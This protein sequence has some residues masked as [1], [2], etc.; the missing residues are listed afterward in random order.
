MQVVEKTIE[1]TLLQTIEKI[2]D[3][4]EI[5]TVQSTQSSESLETAPVLKM[6]PAEKVEGVEFG[7]PLSAESAPPMFA[8][9]PTVEP[10]PVVVEYIQPT[11]VV[12]Y[13]AAA[14]AVTYAALAPMVEYVRQA[15]NSDI[16]ETNEKRTLR[17]SPAD[18]EGLLRS[19]PKRWKKGSPPCWMS[20]L[21]ISTSQTRSMRVMNTYAVSGPRRKVSPAFSGTA[22]RNASPSRNLWMTR[23]TCTVGWTGTV[24]VS[25]RGWLS[26]TWTRNLGTHPLVERSPN[27]WETYT[28]VCCRRRRSRHRSSFLTTMSGSRQSS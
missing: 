14:P 19:S 6:A 16:I 22:T 13:V 17:I 25:K 9:A 5:Q 3:I 26:T 4:P 11:H 1:I 28:F 7:A 18:C 27:M 24:T 10:P 12:E 15:E 2:V 23:D 20:T 21:R 8:T